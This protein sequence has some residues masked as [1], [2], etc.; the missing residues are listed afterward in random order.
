MVLII[1]D[2]FPLAGLLD[3]KGE[4]DAKRF[5]NFAALQQQSDW[6]RNAVTVGDSTEQ[7]VPAILSGD[8]P[9]PRRRR[10]L[11]RPS[12]EPLHPA[13]ILLSDQHLRVGDIPLPDRALLYPLLGHRSV[14]AGA[15][16]GALDRRRRRLSVRFGQQGSARLSR[17]YP[18]GNT[19]D[20]QVKRFIANIKPPQQ[21]RSTP[22]TSSSRTSPGATPRR[23]GP[24]SPTLPARGHDG[25][26]V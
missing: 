16:H 4:I 12:R 14:G 7:A 1:M 21:D 26:L 23:G 19:P 2:E 25:V 20:E 15:G 5:P 11:L 3:S 18:L 8:F 10:Q 17:R 13:R 22:F 9:R 6:F 24:T